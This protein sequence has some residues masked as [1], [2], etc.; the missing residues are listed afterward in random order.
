[1]ITENNSPEAEVCS[2]PIP[3]T[4]FTRSEAEG[5]FSLGE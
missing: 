3:G 1:M 5:L 2:I 4:V